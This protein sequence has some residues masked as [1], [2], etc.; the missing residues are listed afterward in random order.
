MGN[1]ASKVNE[2]AEDG[3]GGATDGGIGGATDGSYSL[4]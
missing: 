1:K 2:L 3:T 4:Y